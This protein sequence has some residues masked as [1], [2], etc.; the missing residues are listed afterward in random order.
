[1]ISGIFYGAKL[2]V[3]LLAF[4]IKKAGPFL[5]LPCFAG[6]NQDNLQFFF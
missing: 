3:G 2:I 6:C 1:M 4:Q 5:T